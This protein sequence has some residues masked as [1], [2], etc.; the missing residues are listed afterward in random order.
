MSIE[1]RWT[2]DLVVTPTIQRSDFRFV[3]THHILAR[4]RRLYKYLHNTWIELICCRYAHI[5]SI[6]SIFHYV[7]YH[8]MLSLS[9]VLVQLWV[10]V[11]HYHRCHFHYTTTTQILST[12]IP[13]TVSTKH[14]IPVGTLETIQRKILIP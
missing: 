4:Q 11:L 3:F 10:V 6:L 9:K 7:L 13:S 14:H 8:F 12:F 2:L 1:Y 5:V